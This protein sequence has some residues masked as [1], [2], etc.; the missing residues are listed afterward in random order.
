[1]VPREQ[2]C[3]GCGIG[4]K[5]TGEVLVACPVC[6]TSLPVTREDLQR[7]VEMDR[8]GGVRSLGDELFQ[9]VGSATT[10][11]LAEMKNVVL[12]T[13]LFTAFARFAVLA[14][15]AR[16]PVTATFNPWLVVGL[17]ATMVI[18]GVVPVV[19]IKNARMSFRKLGFTP[20][21]ARGILGALIAGAAAGVLLHVLDFAGV[22]LRGAIHAA[23]GWDAF[24][25]SPHQQDFLAFMH[26]SPWNK[27]AVFLPYGAAQLALVVFFAGVVVNG[28]C[29][30]HEQRAVGN[31]L[32][33]RTRA[34]I[35]LATTALVALLTFAFTFDLSSVF[36]SISSTLLLS[37]MYLHV[38]RIHALLVA[39]LVFIIVTFLLT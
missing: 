3:P 30:H 10:W 39:N 27:L 14:L 37:G 2:R 36:Y 12:I 32:V 8:T 18:V 23:T 1:M 24:G 28:F 21:A 38:R 31:G 13:V 35:L 6:G 22:F 25:P 4:L 19:Y 26:A 34:R 9:R 17:H 20:L 29:H 16:D 5:V 15:L 33:L 11:T 7:K